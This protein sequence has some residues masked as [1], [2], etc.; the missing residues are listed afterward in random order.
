MTNQWKGSDLKYI[1]INGY[2]VPLA[3]LKG[4][5]GSKTINKTCLTKLWWRIF[6]IRPGKFRYQRCVGGE[7]GDS[8]R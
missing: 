6:A 7:A 8:Y 1:G 5:R 4:Q 3:P 2:G